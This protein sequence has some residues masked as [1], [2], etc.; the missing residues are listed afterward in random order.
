MKKG[1]IVVSVISII[2]AL[3]V[4]AVSSTFPPSRNGVPGPGVV[5]TLIS[6]LILIS[7]VSLLIST[8]LDKNPQPQLKL[9]TPSVCRVY[10]VMGVL[11]VYTILLPILG[12]IIM[13]ALLMGGLFCWFKRK[14]YV[15]NIL[16]CNHNNMIL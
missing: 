2:F 8:I 7:A 11:V 1:N 14:S 16:L 13:N 5:P 12:I 4:M 6:I 3:Y 15:F 9:Y 10:I